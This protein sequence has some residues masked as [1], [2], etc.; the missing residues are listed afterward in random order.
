MLEI[1]VAP[2]WV[3]PFLDEHAVLADTLD[4]SWSMYLPG[5]AE[6]M[7]PSDRKQHSVRHDVVI[8]IH[9]EQVNTHCTC[10]C[11]CYLS[12]ALTEYTGYPCKANVL[13]P[14]GDEPLAQL[15]TSRNSIFV[16][17]QVARLGEAITGC[18]SAKSPS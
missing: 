11:S 13:Y 8:T 18:S 7:G 12:L 3:W 4:S 17:L 5:Q 2:A 1:I 14:G 10:P 16:A 6:S 15:H 9:R